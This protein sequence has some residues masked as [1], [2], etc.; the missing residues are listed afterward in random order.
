[1]R[2]LLIQR[3]AVFSFRTV[4][5]PVDRNTTWKPLFLS[6]HRINTHMLDTP[7]YQLLREYSLQRWGALKGRLNHLKEC[8]SI[9]WLAI[10]VRD[11]FCSNQIQSPWPLANQSQLYLCTCLGPASTY[12]ATNLPYKIL[13]AQ[14]LPDHKTVHSH[15]EPSTVLK[16]PCSSEGRIF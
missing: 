7:I 2:S 13:S 3:V 4:L 9:R 16:N 15:R 6:K 12:F 1:M 11:Q 8:N 10:R 5:I 14:K